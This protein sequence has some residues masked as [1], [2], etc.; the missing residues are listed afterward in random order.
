MT[1]VEDPPITTE[2]SPQQTKI[3]EMMPSRFI[4]HN[5][6]EALDHLK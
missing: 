4:E 5:I 1:D 3:P 2:G 6:T